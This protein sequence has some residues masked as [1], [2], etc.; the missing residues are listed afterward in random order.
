MTYLRRIKEQDEILQT[1]LWSLDH[2]GVGFR[3]EKLWP[4]HVRTD[5]ALKVR[6]STML[7]EEPEVELALV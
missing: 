7:G 1:A 5:N 6:F 4:L 2:G 3:G